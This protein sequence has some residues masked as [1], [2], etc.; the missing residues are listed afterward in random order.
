M[1]AK[2][3]LATLLS[4]PKTYVTNIYGGEGNNLINAGWKNLR[5]ARS[6]DYLNKMN[7]DWKTM[8][9]VEK[10]VTQLGVVEEF[11][12][13]Q[14]GLNPKLRNG[15]LGKFID[16]ALEKIKGNPDLSD[17]SLLEIA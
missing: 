6:I 5:D 2:Y 13:H 4:H 8:K 14:I 1:E 9:D 7:P 16:E 11:I 3:E 17:K 15:K 10:T 12:I